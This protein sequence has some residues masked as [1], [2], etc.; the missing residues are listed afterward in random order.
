MQAMR[1]AVIS[2]D[3]LP[4]RLGGAEVHAVE[5]IKRL[6][7]REHTFDVFVGASTKIS[8]TFPKNVTVHAVSYPKIPNLYGLA[9]IMFAPK[10][11]KRLLRGRDIDLIWAK[12]VFPQGVVAAVIARH[13]KR[14]LYMTAQNPLDYKEELVMK[15]LIPFK[16]LLPN[17][18]TPLVSF[19]L[20]RADVVACVSR[21]AKEQADKL[22]ARRS[23]IIPNG[24]DTTKF[25]PSYR[26]QV[27]EVKSEKLKVKRRV[28]IITTSALIPRNGLDTL[29]DAVYLLPSSL[30]WELVIAGDGP[31]YNNLKLQISKY[32]LEQKV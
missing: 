26:A 23:V 31:L 28:R 20:K 6:A 1:V 9:Y 3:L 30:N 11:I 21:Y 19:A 16:N 14:P 15:G 24:V 4:D 17:L 22:G 12:Q 8:N 29:I 25:K 10:Q 27:E 7:E 2:A 32:K 13:L 18:L 5:L